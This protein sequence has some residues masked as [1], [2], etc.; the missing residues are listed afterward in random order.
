MPEFT[1][2]IGN[3]NY[4]SWS[5]RPWLVMRHF[6]IE[7]DEICIPLYSDMSVPLLKQHSPSA[8][9]PVLKHRDVVVHDSLAICE[10][11]HELFPAAHLWPTDS[12]TRAMARAT[13]AEMHSGFLSLRKH[14]P[15]NCRKIIT[16]S[17]VSENT[18]ANIKRIAAIWETCLTNHK[19]DFLFGEF[20]IADAFFAPVVL[21]FKTY[22]VK[23]NS[24][25][26]RYADTMLAL[27]ELNEWVMAAKNETD[28]LEQFEK[29]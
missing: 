1:L 29:Q 26:Q 6:G 16:L 19:S 15:M 5:L 17:D 24:V 27:P 20:T 2:I 21:R 7:F 12:A 22:N 3:K 11:L 9:V 25:C 10:Y 14:M 23:L 28:V 13:V 18:L 4:S 8:Q